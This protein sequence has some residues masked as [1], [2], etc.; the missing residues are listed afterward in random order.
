MPEPARTLL[1]GHTSEASGWA[2]LRQKVQVALQDERLLG[3]QS[4]VRGGLGELPCLPA[5]SQ[6]GPWPFRS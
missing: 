6:P 3:R 2:H 4:Y 5:C 1:L